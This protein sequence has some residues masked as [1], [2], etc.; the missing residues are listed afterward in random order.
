M[1]FD[2]QR[3]D[4][5]SKVWL[6]PDANETLE[7]FTARGVFLVDGA[8]VSGISPDDVDSIEAGDREIIDKHFGTQGDDADDARAVTHLTVRQRGV[9][10]VVK[11]RVPGEKPKVIAAPREFRLS[12]LRTVQ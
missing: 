12:A 11:F 4:S 1:H 10:A 5:L 3:D 6:R 2:V 8:E 9:M 7:A